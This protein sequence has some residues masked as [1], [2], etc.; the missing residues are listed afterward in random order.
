MLLAIDLHEDFIDVEGIAVTSVL[1][2]QAAC[3][4]GSEL[5]T[6][7]ANR[8]TSDD[9][10]ALC[11]EIFYISVAEIESIVEPDGVANDIGCP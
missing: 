3:I 2:L 11:Q 5:D 1:S 6:P 7:Q 4:D 8:L 9:D 10:A